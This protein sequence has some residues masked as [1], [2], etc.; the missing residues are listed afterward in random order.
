MRPV[1]QL[2]DL[3][4]LD[5]DISA[6]DKSLAEVLARLADD[7]AVATLRAEIERLEAELSKRAPVRR[8]VESSVK[9]IGEQIQAIEKKL[10]SGAITNPRELS[11][12]EEERNFHERHR[13]TDEN[14]LL[15]LMVEMDDLDSA[16]V[17]A[18][19]D[20]ARLETNRKMERAELQNAEA[21]LMGELGDLRSS[22]DDAAAQVA[23]PALAAYESLRKSLNGYAVARVERNM[24]QGC[25]LSLPTMEQQRAKISQGVVQCSSCRRILYIR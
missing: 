24:C 19:E 16:R 13:S 17:K 7:S 4:E 14:R 3:Q 20:L 11:A 18:R 10:Y 6:H 25:R 1:K 8:E 21:R 15:E 9:Q 23:P 5:W 22:R 12:Y 2:Y